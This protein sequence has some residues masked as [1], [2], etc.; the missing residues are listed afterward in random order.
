MAHR[1][2]RILNGEMMVVYLMIRSRQVHWLDSVDRMIWLC[3]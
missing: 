2:C 1:V 3:E